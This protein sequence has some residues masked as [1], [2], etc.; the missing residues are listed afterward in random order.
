M[1][2]RKHRR[3]ARRQGRIIAAQRAAAPQPNAAPVKAAPKVRQPVAVKPAAVIET[4]A[5]VQTVVV[6]AEPTPKINGRTVHFVPMSAAHAELCLEKLVD[7]ERVARVQFPLVDRD[8]SP[9]DHGRRFFNGR[10]LAHYDSSERVVGRAITHFDFDSNERAIGTD[11]SENFAS[12]ITN[13]DDEDTSDRDSFVSSYAAWDHAA[14]EE[15][16]DEDEG[17]DKCGDKDP[18]L[19]HRRD[20]R[21]YGARRETKKTR[22]KYGG[23]WPGIYSWMSDSAKAELRA[24]V[25]KLRKKGVVVKQR[26]SH[27]RV[28]PEINVSVSNRPKPRALPK[29]PV[30]KQ[31]EQKHVGPEQKPQS[32]QKLN[33]HDHKPRSQ[34]YGGVSAPQYGKTRDIAAMQAAMNS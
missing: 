3:D 28:G 30:A 24:S 19:D 18:D 6:V 31:P 8:S 16:E 9:N 22:K 25:Q 17:K 21:C 2:S 34:K 20:Y 7:P 5:P 11:G 26:F 23:R 27:G 4:P 14:D 33:G 10:A 12:R 32:G 15:D 1:R 13:A 29:P